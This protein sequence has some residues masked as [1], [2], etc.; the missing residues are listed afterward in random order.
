AAKDAQAFLEGRI[1][2]LESQL[3]IAVIVSQDG[4]LGTVS[5]G[6][7]VTIA[8]G[9]GEAETYRIV[10]PVEASIAQGRISMEAPV[11]RALLGRKAGDKVVVQAPNGVIHYTVLKVE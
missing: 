7:C 1:R 9:S 6:S 11:G 3:S 5:L 4:H 2:T 8:D 10:A